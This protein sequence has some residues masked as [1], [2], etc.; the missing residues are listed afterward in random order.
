MKLLFVILVG[1]TTL[2]ALGCGESLSPSSS[3]QLKGDWEGMFGADSVLL[4]IS[5]SQ[6][7]L[8]GAATFWRD[9]NP[10]VGAID[11]IVNRNDVEFDIAF[12][13]FS[14]DCTGRVSGDRFTGEFRKWKTSADEYNMPHVIFDGGGNFILER[15]PS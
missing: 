7:T 5:L 1:V 10:T 12:P 9:S 8:V 2:V 15:K 11:G 6:G 13:D 14:I 3:V 4:S